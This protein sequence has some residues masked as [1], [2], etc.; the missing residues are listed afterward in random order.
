[1]KRSLKAASLAGLMVLLVFAAMMPACGGGTEPT[2][3][4]VLGWMG[5]QTGPS[6]VSYQEIIMGMDDYIA[7]MEAT[8]PIEGATVKIIN[9]D[10]RL[11]YS[12][13][14]V[15]YEWLVSQGM[16]V[17]LGYS[18]ATSSVTQANQAVDRI[19]LYGLTAYPT[20]LEAE[21]VYAY[22]PTNALEG[23]AI[24]DYLINIWWPARNMGRPLKVGSVGN[25]TIDTTV[26]YREGFDAVLAQNPGEAVYTAVGGPP[27]QT[28]WAHEVSAVKDCDAIILS[29]VGTSSATFLKEALA[30]GY[31]GQIVSCSNAVL[32]SWLL[33]T[34]MVPKSALD[35]ILVPHFYPLWNDGTPYSDRLGEMLAKYRPSDAVTLKQGTTWL[36]GWMTAEIVTKAVRDAAAKVGARNVDGD[37]INDAFLTL[38]LEIE[39]MPSIAL[40]S[41]ATSHVLQPYFRMI[42]Y[43]AA[44]D[45]WSAVTDWSVV[46]GLAG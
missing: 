44:Q 9:Y 12:R 16:D 33:V 26:Q 24:M 34:G 21:W 18:P 32:G 5:D 2:N 40:A 22:M 7:E 25:T 39:G 8:D 35:G 43:Q 6:A 1:M 45:E 23:Q 3:V 37:A 17:L 28:A 15:G 13:F 46:P 11:E 41:S 30:R 4:V 29:T 42:Q 19:P 10:T 38:D 27:T 20:T 14:P 31:T 36:S